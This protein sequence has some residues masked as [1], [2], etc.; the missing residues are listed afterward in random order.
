MSPA[1][2]NITGD[3]DESTPRAVLDG[4]KAARNRPIHL[5]ISSP[6]GSVVAGLEAL[7]A[8]RDHK[9]GVTTEARGLAAS[10]ASVLLMAGKV[11][12]VAEDALVMVHEVWTTTTGP[13]DAHIRG[14]KELEALTRQLGGIY[15]SRCNK[16]LDEILA[17]MAAETWMDAPRAVAMGFADEIIYSA[18]S[19]AKSNVILPPPAPKI[20]TEAPINILEARRFAAEANEVALRA[21]AK[22]PN[23]RAGSGPVAD[24]V[25]AVNELGALPNANSRLAVWRNFAQ[26]VEATKPAI[27]KARDTIGI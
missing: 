7:A 12:R 20:P 25:R 14:A 23:L 18:Q 8:L 15:A 13:A 4:I 21:V 17:L 5:V 27:E 2:L 22:F 1:V 9:P 10:M 26:K 19:K 3:I 6:G 24:L 16:P 11:R